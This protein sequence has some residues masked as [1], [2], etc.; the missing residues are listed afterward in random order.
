MNNIWFCKYE[1]TRK[2]DFNLEYIKLMYENIKNEEICEYIIHLCNELK[3]TFKE[4]ID[5]RYVKLNDDYMLFI[6]E[7]ED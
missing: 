2:N 4:I 5:N 1:E 6:E 7:L 3:Y